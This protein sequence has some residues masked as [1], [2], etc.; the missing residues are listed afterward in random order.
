MK[1]L[2]CL[3]K[4]NEGIKCLLNSIFNK[5]INMAN[6]ENCP[7]CGN[8]M[9]KGYLNSHWWRIRWSIKKIFWM[10]SGEPLG[11]R[12]LW[13]APTLEAVRCKN[14]RIGIFNY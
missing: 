9:E 8:K 7:I 5:G 11:K 10:W 13:R 4:G 1:F 14:C 2:S 12:A 3:K 6:L